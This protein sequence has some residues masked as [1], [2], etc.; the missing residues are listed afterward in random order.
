MTSQSDLLKAD[1]SGR[2]AQNRFFNEQIKRHGDRYKLYRDRFDAA[3]RFEFE[4]EFPL[5]LMLEQ[6]YRCNL[7][8]PMC[9]QG[10]PKRR[11]EFEP[12]EVQMSRA[13]FDRV[14][15]EAARHAC[16]SIS[17]HVNDEPLLVRDLPE[18]IRFAKDHGF[19]DIIMTTNGVLMTEEKA[20]QVIDAGITHILFS[21]DGATRETY[22]KIRLGGDFGKVLKAIEAVRT[23]RAQKGGI[24]PLVRASFVQ[25]RFN[26]HETEKFIEMFSPLVDLVE[27]QGFSSYYGFSDAMKPVGAHAPESFQCNEPWRKLIV[28]ANGDVLPCCTF[29]GYEVKVGNVHQSSLSEIFNSPAM[30]QLRREFKAGIYQN[31]AC[32]SCSK[33]FFEPVIGGP[34]RE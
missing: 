24:V 5:Y 11:V 14:V 29:Y 23:A 18:R 34:P 8:C 10:L 2:S 19:M 32:A 30:K 28:R 21:V 15:L 31:S 16:P 17:M 1:E 27:V 25:N 20:R 3:G 7:R 22:D 33:S 26:Q 9:I 4:P 12:G 13:L 6:T